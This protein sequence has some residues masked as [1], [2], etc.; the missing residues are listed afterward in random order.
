[1]AGVIGGL[2]GTIIGW[3]EYRIV[4]DAVE[5]KLRETDRGRTAAEREDFECRIKGLRRTLLV[6]TVGTSLFVGYLLGRLMTQ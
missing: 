6:F 3:V 4:G 1:M 5:R 2:L